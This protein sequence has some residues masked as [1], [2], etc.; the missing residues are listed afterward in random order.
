MPLPKLKT[1]EI[2]YDHPDS[3]FRFV[4]SPEKPLLTTP[5]A[6]EMHTR[7]TVLAC[8][9]VL[10]RVAEQMDGIDYLQVFEDESKEEDLW[11]IEDGD[12]GAITG[13][14]PSDY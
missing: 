10:K 3:H 7:E 2:A 6:I 1:Q 13:M 5:A 9:L 14:L 11:F 4:A 8:Y 12:G